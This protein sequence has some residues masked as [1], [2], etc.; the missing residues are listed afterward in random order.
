VNPLIDKNPFIKKLVKQDT[1][2]LK[3]LGDH[4][5]YYRGAFSES[6]AISI[7][8]DTVWSDEY[9]RSN[10]RVVRTYRSRTENSKEPRFRTF[11]NPSAKGFGVDALYQAS[12]QYHWMVTCPHCNHISY[13][14][15]DPA[16]MGG[17]RPNV[18][19]IDTKLKEYVCGL[20]HGILPDE[21]RQNGF[22]HARFPKRER[23]G[24]WINQM[25]RPDR[26]AARIMQ[27]WEDDKNIPGYV[28]NFILGKA[29]TP[30]D[31]LID[32]GMFRQIWTSLRP[33]LNEVYIGVD[34]GHVKHVVVITPEG[35]V[36]L[37]TYKEWDDIEAL[38]NML[39]AQCMVIDAMPDIT[40]PRQLAKKYP[41]RVY[42]A[43]FDYNS[44]RKNVADFINKGDRKGFVKIQRN[45]IMDL[46][47]REMRLRSLQMHLPGDKLQQLIDH[48]TVMVRIQE[49]DEEG[50][51]KLKVF[52]ITQGEAPDHFWF[53]LCYARTAMMRGRVN[54]A[55]IAQPAPDNSKK[56]V[57]YDEK[58]RSYEG[59][60][61]D[62]KKKLRKLGKGKLKT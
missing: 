10:V 49:K 26:P 17:M 40:V 61:P 44:T 18:H 2:K 7:S 52:W 21:A 36:D 39:G 58:T 16:E 34:V 12:N 45:D 57:Y 56:G 6:D 20:C 53:A 32:E 62:Y 8:A 50:K 46:V 43:E 15:W 51:G 28:Y 23:H 30:A 14:D 60:I 4:F 27:Q 41:G 19:T 24:Y 48:S 29:Y 55:V 47:V 11:S 42:C 59:I 38:F 22:W 25:M 37:G 35:V 33:P 13:M 9:D 5:L 3:Q 54:T 1:Q 31:A